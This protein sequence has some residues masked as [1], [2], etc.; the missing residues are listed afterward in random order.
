[1]IRRLS[2]EQMQ[3]IGRELRIARKRD[4]ASMRQLVEVLRTRFGI[5][6]DQ[7]GVWEILQ[8]T[9]EPWNFA[10]R[11]PGRKRDRPRNPRG[12]ATWY[13]HARH[14]PDRE[15]EYE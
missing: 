3:A 1:M 15:Y 11:D 4:R 14:R 9:S 6:T 13:Q 8:L 10:D 7:S 5:G 2:H 12:K